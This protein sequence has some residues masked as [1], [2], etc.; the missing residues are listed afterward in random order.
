MTRPTRILCILTFVC[1]GCMAAEGSDNGKVGTTE[2]ELA[3]L[4]YSASA[5]ANASN[6]STAKIPIAFNAN[7]T[8][9]IGTQ[10]I[11]ESSFN[12]NTYLRLRNAS[13]DNLAVNDDYCG[14]PGSRLSFTVTNAI[15]Y[16]LWAGCFGDLACGSAT[17]PNVVAISRRK[18]TY[19]LSASNTDNATINTINKQFY[20]NGGETIRVSTCALEATGASAVGDTYLRLFVNNGGV[21]TEV[22]SNDNAVS[23][24]SC[25]TASLILF[26]ATLSGYYQVR[27]GCALNT[28]CSG[29]VA[30]YGE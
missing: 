21:L 11:T 22:A 16:T 1:S 12:G 2:Q 14:T 20:L 6:A 8:L 27:A 13:L 19:I 3:A 4:A 23:A 18:G 5:T 17:A 15:T 10:G 26:T 29:T 7:E 28:S 30:I 24:C 25:G 9:M